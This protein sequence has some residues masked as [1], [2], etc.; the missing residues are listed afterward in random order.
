MKY[1]VYTLAHNDL[2]FYIGKGSRSRINH[3]EQEALRGHDCP[4]CELIRGIWRSGGTV[5]RAIV[6]ETEDERAALDREAALIQHYGLTQL[7]N[8][9][10]GGEPGRRR[11]ITPVALVRRPAADA[12]C[13]ELVDQLF[14]T[15]VRPDGKEYTYQEVSHAL[16]GELDPTLIG[17]LRSG[18][19]KNPSRNTLKLLCSFFKVPP[20]YFFPDL[21]P[22]QEQIATSEQ[23]AHMFL[24]SLELD[25]DMQAHL[26]AFVEAVRKRDN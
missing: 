5:Q 9:T 10:S 8:R 4:K 15:H 20:S 24:R 23:E 7:V 13:A 14:K 18:K 3:H 16:G 17:K 6:F 12:D 1:Y 2:V 19:T 22:I 26:K 11:R 25:P 21:S